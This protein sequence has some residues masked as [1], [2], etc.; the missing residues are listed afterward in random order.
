MSTDERIDAL[1][2]AESELATAVAIYVRVL[3][4]Q[5]GERVAHNLVADYAASAASKSKRPL[6][7]GVS[8]RSN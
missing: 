3:G 2:M 8:Q 6:V 4:E 7:V 5:E 1:H